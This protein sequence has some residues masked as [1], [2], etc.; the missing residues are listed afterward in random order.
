MRRY[1]DVSVVVALIFLL[2]HFG[3]AYLAPNALVV[4]SGVVL[5]LILYI[6]LAVSSERFWRRDSWILWIPEGLMVFYIARA[7]LNIG[8]GVPVLLV[9][10]NSVDLC[11]YCSPLAFPWL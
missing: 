6:L 7:G 1:Y 5:V 4:K 2:T 10:R 3:G 11:I 8:S 9:A